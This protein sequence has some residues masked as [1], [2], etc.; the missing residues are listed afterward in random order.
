[1]LSICRFDFIEG[2]VDLLSF[3]AFFQLAYTPH[4]RQPV[5]I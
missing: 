1:M 5:I 2:G 4:Q 3:I